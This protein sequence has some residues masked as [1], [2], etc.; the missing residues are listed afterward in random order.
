MANNS[1]I[2]HAVMGARRGGGGQ[3]Q[4]VALLKFFFL[5][6]WGTFL[7]L[8]SH[9]RWPFRHMGAFSQLFSL[10]GGGGALFTMC[11][12]FFVFIG[13]LL[14]FGLAPPLL[15]KFL[16]TLMHVAPCSFSM[17]CCIILGEPYY[18]SSTSLFY[19]LRSQLSVNRL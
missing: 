15:R 11:G 13:G 9:Y 7:L 19:I 16:R 2:T 18:I 17:A 5:S 12:T 10:M 6:I 3:E 4:A 14:W 8:F 1:Y